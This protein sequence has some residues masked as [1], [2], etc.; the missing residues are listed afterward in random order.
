MTTVASWDITPSF[1]SRLSIGV[2]SIILRQPKFTNTH[3]HT[4]GRRM[5][6]PA[7]R[8]VAY[9]GPGG[10]RWRRGQPQLHRHH[11]KGPASSC[12]FYQRPKAAVAAPRGSCNFQKQKPQRRNFPG[13]WGRL[14]GPHPHH[15]VP[16]AEARGWESQRVTI[17]YWR[18][19]LS[20]GGT[21]GAHGTSRGRRTGS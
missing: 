3:T 20:S 10:C 19:S 6:G 15:R 4:R 18:G 11:R 16:W 1:P 7:P 12:Q 2:H 9:L 17:L 5:E 14:M 21:S 13:A 8:Q